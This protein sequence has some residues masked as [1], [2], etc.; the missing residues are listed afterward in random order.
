[1]IGDVVLVVG[2]QEAHPADTALVEARESI[3]VI[4]PLQHGMRVVAQIGLGDELL[5]DSA[6]P[7]HV[8]RGNELTDRVVVAPA[9]VVELVAD[10]VVRVGD[11]EVLA[12]SLTSQA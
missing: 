4:G 1:M 2:W 3:P 5:L 12:E 9:L 6:Q 11:A 7:A 10:V 8:K